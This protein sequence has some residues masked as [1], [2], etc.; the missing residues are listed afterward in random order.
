MILGLGQDEGKPMIHT[1][2]PFPWMTKGSVDEGE[3]M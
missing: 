2:G 1:V 3:E